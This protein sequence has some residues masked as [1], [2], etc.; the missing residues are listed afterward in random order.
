[1]FEMGRVPSISEHHAIQYPTA[2]S[3]ANRRNS[4]R[5]PGTCKNC[6]AEFFP[7]SDSKFCSRNCV[8]LSQRKPD[9][10]CVGCGGRF[11]RSKRGGGKDAARYCSRECSFVHRGNLSGLKIKP[12][13]L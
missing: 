11:R 2:R 3:H 8:G 1:M 7:K 12:C 6:G 4:K 13:S 5:I 10:V 9:R